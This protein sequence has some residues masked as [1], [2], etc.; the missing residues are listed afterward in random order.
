M[1][2]RS[3]VGPSPGR[4]IRLIDAML[5]GVIHAL[6]LHVAESFFGMSANSLQLGNPVDRVYRQ[7]ETINFVFDGQFQWSIDVALFL[8][9]TDVE[10][11]VVR[12]PVR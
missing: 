6:Y 3:L 10:I 5:V 7:T 8:V 2:N 9:A 11:F 4:N 1:E 12:P